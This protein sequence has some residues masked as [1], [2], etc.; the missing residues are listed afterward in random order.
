MRQRVTPKQIARALDVSESSVK[1]W[2]DKG[3]ITTQ[4]TAGGHRRVPISGLV[5]FLRDSK[6]ELVHPEALGIP[7]TS[8]ATE[9]VVRRA[10]EA[11][12]AALLAG[13][14]D[15]C[16][17]IAV[18]LY[19]A[20]H[21]ISEIC[22]QVFAEAFR[23]IGNLWECGEAQIYQERRGCEITYRVLFELQT[24]LPT[25]PENA[26]LA[27]GGATAGD[28]YL[29]GTTMAELVLRQGGWR[30]ASLGN[31]L[32][33]SSLTTAI[34]RQKPRLFWLS[35]SHLPDVDQ[36]LVDYNRLY[37]RTHEQTAI[38]VGGVALDERLR[39][40]MNFSA[41]CENMQ[42]LE[43]FAKTLVQTTPANNEEPRVTKPEPI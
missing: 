2:C 31:N 18:D 32:P 13:D 42:R 33:L 10:T 5:D 21:T 8:G 12:V 43:A 17:Q 14:E 30:A 28:P 27:I 38:V 19:L 34:E 11:M 22:D 36:F 24:L 37:E 23:R 9:R 20:R 39:Q 29:L 4:Y 16:R 7:P 1:R 25:P 41:Y 3:T 26:P 40:Q 35:C 15:R 6:Y